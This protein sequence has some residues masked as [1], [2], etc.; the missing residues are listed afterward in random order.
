MYQ[1]QW[2]MFTAEREWNDFIS[3]DPVIQRRTCW[4]HTKNLSR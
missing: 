4:S 3:Y 2:E 1:M